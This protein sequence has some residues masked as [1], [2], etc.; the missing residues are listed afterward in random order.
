MYL[1][2]VA[3]ADIAF[4]LLVVGHLFS[5]G[6]ALSEGVDHYTAHDVLEQQTEEDVVNEVGGEPPD[7]ELLHTSTNR[8]R[9]VKIQYTVDYTLAHLLGVLLD[10]DLQGVT[11]VK[12]QAE[13]VD[14]DQPQHADREQLVDV[15]GDGLEDVF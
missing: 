12:D 2:S 10:H 4:V 13:D 7:F 5:L 1:A 9:H 14:K 6:S 15:E 11:L 8:P 3:A